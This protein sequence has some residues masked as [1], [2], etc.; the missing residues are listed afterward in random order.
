[1]TTVVRPWSNSARLL[2]IMASLSVSRLE[3]ASSRSRTRGRGEEGAGDGHPLPLAARELHA[4]LADDGFQT[5]WESIG[6][7]AHIGLPGRLLDLSIRRARAGEAQVLADCAVEEEVVLEDE[8]E[9]LPIRGEQDLPQVYPV[10]EALERIS[11]GTYGICVR[12]AKPITE[13]R[14]EAAPTPPS[15]ST[16]RTSTGHSES[17]HAKRN[18]LRLRAQA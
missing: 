17:A 16:A 6:E 5:F 8:T 2:W 1:M 7:L 3:V 13:A 15:A 14:L 18:A 9:L 11:E 4:A 10:D 12:C